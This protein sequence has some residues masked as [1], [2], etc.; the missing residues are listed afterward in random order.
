MR[1][2]LLIGAGALRAAEA[3]AREGASQSALHVIVVGDE[4]ASHSHTPHTSL[5]GFARFHLNAGRTHLTVAVGE[6]MAALRQLRAN[7]DEFRLLQTA[8][9]GDSVHF[10]RQLARLA[11]PG[12]RLVVENAPPAW[13]PLRAAGFP[14]PEGDIS[15]AA[16]YR[17]SWH[18]HATR[19]T[20]NARQAIVI[21][22]GLAGTAVASR[23]A[24]RGWKIQLVDRAPGPAARASGNLAGVM[25]PMVSRDDNR[26]SR[27]SRACFF[28]LLRELESLGQ[29]STPPVWSG[30]GVMQLAKTPADA[31]LHAEIMALRQFPDTFC[32]HLDATQVRQ[33]F[34]IDA[35]AS[36]L[37]FP[38]GGWV[39]PPSLCRARLAAYPAIEPRFNTDISAVEQ[40]HDAWRVFAK[41]EV[42]AEAPVLIL[43]NSAD[44]ARL[45]VAASLHFK[46]VRGQVTHL[47]PPHAR[48]VRAVLQKDGYLTP[49]VEGLH[50]LGATYDFDDPDPTVRQDSHALNLAR[51]QDMV[52]G[53]TAPLDPAQLGGRVGFRAL[54][55][56]RLPLVGAL[57]SPLATAP[58][59][60]AQLHDIPRTPAL[61]G[62][63]GLGSRG[64]VWSALIGEALASV[65]N[66][67][68]TPIE[69]D[70]M[71]AI[72][73]ARFMLRQRRSMCRY[74]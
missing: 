45:P 18:R 8:P 11:T 60:D 57:P 10:Y 67:E 28:Y 72:D 12:A 51:L 22:A 24:A 4:A 53:F 26:A 21:G 13:A 1:V 73:P 35:H 54:T 5:P 30:C 2:V 17:G 46:T 44:A 23:L 27:L 47:P 56:D 29:T 70:L 37:Y 65:I 71:E 50:C 19:A 25:S 34:G 43:A 36:G 63:L 40:V 32:Q 20:T 16:I 15:K 58:A 7:V 66:G 49:P 62:A 14:P 9:F 52:P 38:S 59:P 64:L 33:K 74:D 61:F 31:A 55:I 68:P 39:M 6:P 42:V 3:L 41:G 48:A 69:H